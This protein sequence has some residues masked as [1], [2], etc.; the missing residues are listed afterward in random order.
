M[1]VAEIREKVAHL[2]VLYV[3][4][5]KTIREDGSLFFRKFFASVT[6]AQ[7]GQEAIELLH[8]NTYDLV[9][10]DLKMP[11]VS[12]DE[13]FE[14]AKEHFPSLPVVIISGLSSGDGVLLTKYPYR[15]EKP[16]NIESFISLLASIY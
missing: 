8:H 13:L 1:K 4:D 7:N 12:G 11:K 6:T 3:E 16:W 15:L 10:S 2:N 14:Y 5:E 9:I